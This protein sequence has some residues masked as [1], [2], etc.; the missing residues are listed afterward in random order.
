MRHARHLRQIDSRIVRGAPWITDRR[1]FVFDK[2]IIVK[3]QQITTAGHAITE[4]HRRAAVSRISLP[5][6]GIDGGKERVPYR[7][8]R[9]RK[10][11]PAE[12]AGPADPKFEIGIWLEIEFHDIH[13]WLFAQCASYSGHLAYGRVL[14]IHPMMAGHF[15][16]PPLGPQWPQKFEYARELRRVRLVD[17]QHV[18]RLRV[19]T[20]QKRV[21]RWPGPKR[22]LTERCL[23]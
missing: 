15:A 21:L 5:A 12:H 18:D 23:P 22:L 1:D 9:N 17:A 20:P 7:S 10:I 14:R 4:I 2:R 13:H 16:D 8:L 3:R 11:R 6:A 19:V